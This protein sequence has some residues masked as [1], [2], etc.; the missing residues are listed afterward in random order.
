MFAIRRIANHIPRDKLRNV[1]DSLWTSKLR[2]GLQLT[3]KV[4]LKEEDKSEQN[5]KAVQIAQNKF[6][7]K[8]KRCENIQP[9][10]LSGIMNS[11]FK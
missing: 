3:T 11:K 5:T 8:D 1:A 2:Y 6:Y 9:W 4:R 7:T 10:W